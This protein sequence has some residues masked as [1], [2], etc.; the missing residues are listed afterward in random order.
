LI[1]VF[2]PDCTCL[3]W[4]SNGFVFKLMT[5][6]LHTFFQALIR[7]IRLLILLPVFLLPVYAC[8]K[9]TLYDGKDGLS[10]NLINCIAKDKRGMMWIGTQNG[11]NIYDGY[12]FSKIDGALSSLNINELIATPSGKELWVGTSQGLYLVNLSTFTTTRCTLSGGKDAKWTQG[13]AS[14][15][16]LNPSGT[17]LYLS[18]AGGY[19]VK[20]GGKS[21]NRIG[22]LE[23]TTRYIRN[24]VNRDAGNLLVSNGDIYNLELATGKGRYMEEFR[25]QAP[26]NS[27][28]AAGDTLSLNGF[29]SG[30]WLFNLKTFKPCNP[31]RFQKPDNGFPF[32]IRNNQLFNGRLFMSG[33]NYSFFIYNFST[34]SYTDVSGK[35]PDLFEGKVYRNMFV[36]E[37]N[38]LWIA[39]NKGLLK[40][41]ER[42]VLFERILYN[43]PE[44]VS[45]RKMIEDNTG[46]LYIASYSGLYHY[47]KAQQEWHLYNHKSLEKN[48]P[49]ELNIPYPNSLLE[50]SS[51]TYIYTGSEK[52]V[53]FNKRKK[54]YE[55]LGYTETGKEKIRN[56]INI[57][58]D[59][60]GQIWLACENGLASYDPKKNVLQLH[61]NDAFD[62]GENDARFIYADKD[63]DVIYV[64]TVSGLFIVDIHKGITQ[65]LSMESSPAL[66]NSNIMFIDED[67]DNNLWL[68]TN[69][70]GI[71]IV[72]ADRKHVRYILK[73][74]GLSSE[75]VYSML[76]EDKNTVWIGTFNGLARYHIRQS[77]FT[78]FFEEDGLSSNEFNHNSYLKARDGKMYF[79]SING[80]ITFYPQHIGKPQPFTIFV[81]GTSRWNEKSQ[82]VYLSRKE[83]SLDDVILKNPSDLLLEF[84]FGCTDYSEPLRNTF[85]YRI[86]H[87]SDNWISMDDKHTLN[88]GGL[89]YGEYTIEVRATNA[90]GT[91]SA[92]VLK[93]KIKVVQPFYKTWWFYLLLLLCIGGIFYA[94]Y[95]LQY[96]SLKNLHQLRLRI[97]SNL[98]DDVGSLLTRIT[99][100]SENLR[101]GRNTEE[102]RNAKLDKIALLSRAA[103]ASMSDVLWTIDS[104]NDFAGNLLDRMREHAE[105]MLFPLG[106]EVNFVIS[107]TDLKRYIASNIRRDIYLLFKEAINNIARHSSADRVD[108][109]YRI[110]VK[111]FYLKISNNGVPVASGSEIS[112]GQG[113]SN[114][115]M[116]AKKTGASVN[117]SSQG[118]L[119]IIEIQ[120]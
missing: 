39:T 53:G 7:R 55:D 19:I 59:R 119:F 33:N 71:N 18:F 9:A 95:L 60:H 15:L 68:G 3:F 120:K 99:M 13:N 27:M 100:F 111:G 34:D 36:D 61:K 30:I 90:Q 108:I 84:H 58:R 97:S 24:I 83:I 109:I 44:R 114:I 94:I 115:K 79:G 35:Y 103:V 46:D 51:G 75:I 25:K 104:R 70:G 87:L 110:N 113:L 116:R 117:I 101:Y 23:D 52:L 6:T 11:L 21:I 45:T 66:T 41:E 14:G 86:E 107:G 62:I 5:G 42:P 28:S 48:T 54:I 20:A 81:S 4:E 80:V 38:I 26:Y 22:R 69:G 2:G 77:M 40:V 31:A 8:A 98:H 92:N 29:G 65:H 78:F 37:R 74:N 57:E 73:Q 1:A 91:P 88:L 67:E 16:C 43:L 17:Q 64:G 12:T 112:T 32:Y 105:E 118:G 49:P 102:Q 63:Q 50:D 56:I 106:I 47:I 10:S 89:P 85:T 72:S 96:Q 76:R 93:F 82:S